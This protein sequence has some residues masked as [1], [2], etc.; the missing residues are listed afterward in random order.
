MVPP[1]L[2]LRTRASLIHPN[3]S[4]LFLVFIVGFVLFL[5]TLFIL[6]LWLRVVEELSQIMKA[7]AGA[8]LSS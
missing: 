3:R 7:T 4:W 1:G 6:I 5:V 2:S 8:V